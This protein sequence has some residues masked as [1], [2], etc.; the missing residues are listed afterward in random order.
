MA[1]PPCA[2]PRHGAHPAGAPPPAFRGHQRGANGADHRTRGAHGDAGAKTRNG[3]QRPLL[4]EPT[5]L[6]VRV[7][8]HAAELREADLAP[9]LLAAA[10][11][12]L[13]RRQCLWADMAS[14]GQQLR[15]WVAEECG[16]RLELVE[17]PRRWG[18]YPVDVAP[19]PLPAFPV[20]PRRGVVE[21]TIA[22][23]GRH[24]RLSKGYEDLP[25]S[26]E[27]MIDVAMSRLMLRRLARQAPSSGPSPQRQGLRG[28]AR[29]F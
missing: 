2:A 13:D 1:A 23:M 11:E 16:W 19:P 22:W 29:V 26:R 21:R 12:A 6:L 27:A 3:R 14:R 28:L 4:G 18:W 17:R 5:G 8:G 24:R 15:T 9:W 25:E 7:L 20:L 10:D